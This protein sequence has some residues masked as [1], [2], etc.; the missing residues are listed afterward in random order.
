MNTV[1]E[2]DRISD[3]GLTTSTEKKQAI[4]QSV[5]DEELATQLIH[6]LIKAQVIAGLQPDKR[7]DKEKELTFSYLTPRYHDVVI[8]QNKKPSVSGLTTFTALQREITQSVLDEIAEKT[9]L[10]FRLAEGNE[11]TDLVFGNFHSP[12]D[13]LV[14]FVNFNAPTSS[15]VDST[16]TVASKRD[17]IWVNTKLK[18]RRNPERFKAALVHEIGHALGLD[19]SFNLEEPGTIMSYSWSSTGLQ[20]ADFLALWTLHG[21]DSHPQSEERIKAGEQARAQMWLRIKE[22]MQPKNYWKKFLLRVDDRWCAFISVNKTHSM[23]RVDVFKKGAQVE[24]YFRDKTYAEIRIRNHTGK[25]I[26]EKEI[27]GTGMLSSREELP[28]T[29]GYQ[30]EIYHAEAETS[31]FS[32]PNIQG[33]PVPDAKTNRFIM[34]KTGL[35]RLIPAHQMTLLDRN[36][37]AFA[38]LSVDSVAGQ[39]EIDISRPPADEDAQ[40][41]VYAS[42]K[43]I[44]KK[45][46]VVFKKEIKGSDTGMLRSRILFSEG[47]KLEIYHAQAEERLKI[48]SSGVKVDFAVDAKTTTFIMTSKGLEKCLFSPQPTQVDT[49]DKMA[50]TISGFTPPP[51]DA[52]SYQQDMA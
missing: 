21:R 38:S 44:N 7:V 52:V 30:L 34:T 32:N 47:D 20:V 37:Y 27:K 5:V 9:G 43:V 11:S 50:Q 28:F 31:L 18:A 10:E 39:L 48:F 2:L 41:S 8:R 26:F 1:E 12:K 3:V 46:R 36:N 33:E 42:I 15:L 29:E 13:S 23:L 22:D 35:K 6:Y 51:L 17:E 40:D 19:H 49:T 45:G 25:V 4:P 24:G 14:G 16:T